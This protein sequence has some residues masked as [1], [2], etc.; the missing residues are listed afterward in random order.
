MLVALPSAIAFGLIIYSPLGAGFAAQ[1]A[2]AGILGTIA[3][4]LV[5][6]SFGGAPRLVSAPCGP[7]A[8]V[9]AGFVVYL[10][11]RTTPGRGLVC[12]PATIIVLL[13]LLA[14]I[15]GG[16]QILFGLVGGGRIIKY[17]PYPVVAG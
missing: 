2:I 8:A 9:L 12:A 4:G 3:I 6:P 17:I 11:G 15:A 10:V 14:L 16:L 7:A 13:A 1:G 5:A